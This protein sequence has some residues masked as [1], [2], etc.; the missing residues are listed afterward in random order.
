M[1]KPVSERTHKKKVGDLSRADKNARC[2]SR[3]AARKAERLAKEAAR[4]K[5]TKAEKLAALARGE[6]FGKKET[7]KL[8]RGS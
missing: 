5:R 2:K 6:F 7:E 1:S 4:P 3:N 8:K